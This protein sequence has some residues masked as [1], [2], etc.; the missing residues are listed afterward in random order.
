M[1][2]SEELAFVR[3]AMRRRLLSAHVVQEAVERKRWDAPDRALPMIL[4]DMGA[5]E[6]NAAAELKRALSEDKRP[7]RHATVEVKDPL[8]RDGKAGAGPGKGSGRGSGTIVREDEEELPPKVPRQIA[9]YRLVRLLGAGAMGA[10]YLAEHVEIRREVALKLLLSEGAPSPRAIARFKREARLAAKLDHPNIVRVFEAGVSP[11]GQHYIAM[12]M[13]KGRSVAELLAL[14]EVTPRR[15]VHIMRKVAEAVG[16]AH[17]QGVIHR[18]LKPANVLVEEHSGEARVTDFGL[19]TMAEPDEDDKLTRTG[20]AVGTPAYMAPEQVKGQ[21]DRIDARTDVYA[22]GATLYE[23]LTGSPPFEASTFLDLAKRICEHDAVHPRRKNPLVPEAVDTICLKALEKDP[24]ER[25][26]TAQEMAKDLAAFL[27]DAPIVARPPSI[28]T[29]ARRY[30]RRRPATVLTL[31][32]GVGAACGLLG[33]QLTRPGHL[34][35]ESTPPGALLL[36][37]D[38]EVGQVPPGGLALDVAAGRHQL[39]FRL[40]GYLEHALGAQEVELGHGETVRLSGRLVSTKGILSLVSSP[41]G[42]EVEVLAA[43]GSPITSGTTDFLCRLEAGRYRVRVRRAPAG[44]LTPSETVAAEVAPGG[45]QTTLPLTLVP[46]RAVLR[47]ESDPPEDVSVREVGGE[48]QFAPARLPGAGRHEVVVS[49]AGYLARRIVETVPPGGTVERRVSLEPLVSFRRP[50]EGRIVAGPL[51]RDLDADGFPDLAVLEEGL[52]GRRLVVLPGG[53]EEQPRFRVP[54]ASRS[55]VEAEDVNSDGVLDL[56]LGH[57]RGLE[58]RD[59]VSGRRLAVLEGVDA[60]AVSVYRTESDPAQLLF[61]EEGLRPCRLPVSLD[62]GSRKIEPAREPYAAP[63]IERGPSLDV[64]LFPLQGGV[65]VRPLSRSEGAFDVPRLDGVTTRSSLFAVWTGLSYP[66]ALALPRSGPAWV[67]DPH[68]PGA[69]EGKPLAFSGRSYRV[70]DADG[71]YVDACAVRGAGGEGW[72][73][74]TDE[75]KG[76]Q[77][78]RLVPERAVAVPLDPPPGRHP[79]RLVGGGGPA[80]V[81]ARVW[82]RA[83]E[84]LE[85]GPRGWERLPDLCTATEGLLAPDAAPAVADLDR[86]GQPEL[87][88]PSPDRRSLVAL[89]PWPE[90][91]RWRVRSPAPLAAVPAVLGEAVGQRDLLLLLGDR[92]LGLSAQDGQQRLQ[93]SLP[94]PGR[95]VA[96]G[97]P[98]AAGRRSAVYV[99]CQAGS[100]ERVQRWSWKGGQWGVVWDEERTAAGMIAIPLDR[101]GDGEAELLVGGP[102]AL[103]GS[104]DGKPLWEGD[105]GAPPCAPAWLGGDDPLCLGLGGSAA[106]PTLVARGP[107]GKVRWETALGPTP[108]RARPGQDEGEEGETAEEEQPEL[109]VPRVLV[110]EGLDA[111]AVLFPERVVV[112]D[113]QGKVRWRREGSFLQGALAGQL[114]PRLVLVSARLL[115]RELLGLEALSGADAWRHRLPGGVQP[116][117]APVGWAVGKPAREAVALVAPSG[118]ALV[119]ALDDG[120]LLGE[121]RGLDTPWLPWAGI[122]PSP[123][124]GGEPPALLLARAD[125]RLLALEPRAGEPTLDPAERR[126]VRLRELVRKTELGEPFVRKALDELALLRQQAPKDLAAALALAGAQLALGSYAEARQV[127]QE[128][129]DRVPKEL[130]LRLPEALRIQALTSYGLSRPQEE[131]TADLQELAREDPGLA[132]ETALELSRRARRTRDNERELAFLRQAVNLA[133]H[134]PDARR[135]LGLELLR[136]RGWSRLS[137][138]DSASR[139]AF[140]EARQQLAEARQQLLLGLAGGEDAEARAGALLAVLLEEQVTQLFLDKLKGTRN[141]II[142]AEEERLR[143]L[144]TLA[145]ALAAGGVETGVSQERAARTLALAREVHTALRERGFTRGRNLKAACGRLKLFQPRWKLLLDALAA[146]VRE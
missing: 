126:R 76:C 47:V 133:P 70:G 69:G 128:T 65:L 27:D 140:L 119:V 108:G 57:E 12:E 100:A 22:L 28:A 6:A 94:G 127:A 48:G 83:G 103:L 98:F 67:F 63:L 80:D 116:C 102:L 93:V 97:P 59:G 50:M 122:T 81:P 66:W 13:V 120:Q 2:T 86:D 88:G 8:A 144:A 85:L 42:A 77:L 49:K 134:D 105:P 92:L 40:D 17:T 36:V 52:D 11:E 131:V 55:L 138:D 99:A 141:P 5:I 110:H 112:T 129:R 43:D 15:A 75:K 23:L 72:L 132:V 114:A 1:I 139:T 20:A 62:P 68:P 90:R 136:W 7:G 125:G 61:L 145:D 115:R 78:F 74:L 96:A 10:V 107:D 44:F 29:Q 121:R 19:A 146:S 64:A 101:D 89:S 54:T 91:V 24:A 18:D 135:S 32:G 51:V 58:V 106:E 56:V 53:G 123:G 46:D 39:R 71:Q 38:R 21:L 60:G 143:E 79:V 117:S 130:R 118:V 4:V 31:V 113:R 26:Q 3:L 104:Q 87:V 16:Y 84:V 34:V 109:F 95:H 37:D 111:V 142:Q 33:W 35:V 41:S 25:Y 124:A 45:D 82:T 30:A 9:G 14:N 137:W 73:F